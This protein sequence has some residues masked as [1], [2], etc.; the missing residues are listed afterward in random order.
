M[1]Q[2]GVITPVGGNRE[3]KL[4]LRVIA[5]THR[6]LDAAV[7]SGAFREDLFHRVRVISIP[8]RS[9]AERGDEFDRI[10]HECLADVCARAGRSI[11]RVNEGAAHA[12]EAHDWPGN[13]RELRNV[14]EY[15]VLASDGDEI[16]VSD[17]P[18]WF[19]E[20]KRTGAAALAASD[21]V[22]DVENSRAKSGSGAGGARG[23]GR[24]EIEFQLSY[25]RSVAIF[26]K[27]YFSRVL[28]RYGWRVSRAARAIGI[29]KA[30]LLRRIRA[31]DL[32]SPLRR[33]E[34]EDSELANQ[35][36]A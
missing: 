18:G 17:L 8:L 4:D 3:V 29:S 20:R 25:E 32:K 34:L 16:C 36:S 35:A 30:T 21:T 22:G 11:L 6:D 28:A 15:S 24:W 33:T 26:E 19:G 1:L 23:I 10:L 13:F 2:S 14:L 12:L 31:L 7:A 5:A 9:L 27:E